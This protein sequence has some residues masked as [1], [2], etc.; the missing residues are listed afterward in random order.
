M[1]Y[2]LQLQDVL[3]FPCNLN[4]RDLAEVLAHIVALLDAEEVRPR[5][6]ERIHVLVL[7]ERSDPLDRLEPAAAA[8]RLRHDDAAGHERI[9]HALALVRHRLVGLH[10]RQR[11]DLAAQVLGHRLEL[12]ADLG[13][14][15]VAAGGEEPEGR[16]E[17]GGCAKGAHFFAAGFAAGFD[18]LR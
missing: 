6:H 8:R 11:V 5:A 18:A 7:R 3:A 10:R 14:A 16:D 13:R 15:L 17:R 2:F 9:E 1:D 12:L 4:R